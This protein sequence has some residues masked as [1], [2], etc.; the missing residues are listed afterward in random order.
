[1]EIFYAKNENF[2]S[3]VVIVLRRW[4]I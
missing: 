2:G 3:S 4:I 1:M